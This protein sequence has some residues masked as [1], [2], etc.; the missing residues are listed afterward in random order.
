VRGRRGRGLQLL[1]GELDP[2]AA[3]L[4]GQSAARVRGVVGDETQP[5]TVLAQLPHGLRSAGDRRAGDVE[6]A[7]DVQENACHGRRV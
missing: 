7:V 3:D 1:V 4:L 5:V 2:E 6:N